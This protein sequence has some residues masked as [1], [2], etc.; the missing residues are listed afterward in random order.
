MKDR[1]RALNEWEIARRAG[2]TTLSYAQ[3]SQDP[4]RGGL[5][6]A[7]ALLERRGLVSIWERGNNYDTFVPTDRAAALLDPIEAVRLAALGQGDLTAE[8]TVLEAPPT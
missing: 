1:I 2:H 6:Q 7:L 4:S 3:Y 5:V 8:E